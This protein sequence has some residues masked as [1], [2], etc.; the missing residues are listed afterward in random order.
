M[1]A[2]YTTTDHFRSHL[3]TLQVESDRPVT[4]NLFYDF[5]N[6]FNE[7]LM[8]ERKVTTIDET[9]SLYFSIPA[10]EQLKSLRMDTDSKK[11]TVHIDSAT[12]NY[13]GHTPYEIP[14]NRVSAEGGA[15]IVSDSQGI[16]IHVEKHASDPM[17]L[18]NDLGTQPGT[19]SREVLMH[20][21]KAL[22]AA[23]AILFFGL[24]LFRYFFQA[25]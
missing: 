18:F 9:T 8:Q 10:W 21:A 14:L 20:Y 23:L 11:V 3:L 5:G 25:K 12:L 7:L 4:L 16:N 6:G 17:I 1:L 22:F 19:S 24:A 2:R 13:H 15:Q